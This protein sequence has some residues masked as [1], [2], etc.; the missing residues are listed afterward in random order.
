VVFGLGGAIGLSAAV[1][2]VAA[3]AV[4]PVRDVRT[5][6]RRVPA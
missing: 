6:P 2:L 5:L 3:P 4:L 1:I